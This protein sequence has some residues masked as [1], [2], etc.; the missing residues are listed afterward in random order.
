M[1]APL[2][3]ALIALIAVLGHFMALCWIYAGHSNLKICQTSIYALPISRQ[4]IRRELLN[5]L[6]TPIHAAILYVLVLLNCFTNHTWPS[7]GFS[8]TLTTLWAET[9]HYISH[10]AFH[11]SRLH[12]IHAEHHK[13]H[14]SS[15]FTALSFSFS[16]KLIFNL[17]ILGVLALV[18]R[19]YGLNF[20]GIA[21]WYVGYLV[22][23]SF[24]H[25]NFEM[26]SGSFQRVA[27]KLL[28]ST[29]YHALH[30]SRFSGI[31]GL[32]TRVFDRMFRTEW[33]DYEA[34]FG[35]I[36]EHKRPLTRLGERVTKLVG[37]TSG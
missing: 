4:Q 21:L 31:Y 5:S 17:G 26:K 16:E 11:D 35:Q 22:I 10:R 34:V 24:S 9:W 14:V 3:F 6:H 20:F 13:S 30:H 8:L 18:D 15:P 37:H 28:T 23:N 7:F 19:F 25:A 2:E 27:G 33:E 12:W 36:A 29:T 32:G 1:I